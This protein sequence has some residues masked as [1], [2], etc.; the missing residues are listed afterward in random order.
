MLEEF[1]KY[2]RETQLFP[3]SETVLLAVSG[4]IDSIVMA[5]L[6]ARANFSFAI[7]HCNFRLRGEAS[8]GDEA[9]VKGLAAHYEVP[10]F[11]KKFDTEACAKDKQV[12]IQM[13]ARELRYQWFKDITRE[14]D[15]HHIALAHHQNDVLETMLFNLSKGTGLSGLHGILPRR[16]KLIRPLLFANKVMIENF[17]SQN[18]LEWREDSSNADTK[19]TRN[20]LRHKVLPV[21]E[22]INPN[23]YQTLQLTAERI[24]GAETLMLYLVEQ[25][26]RESTTHKGQDFFIHLPKLSGLPGLAVIIHEL[27][28][29]YGFQYMQSREIVLALNQ[30]EKQKVGRIFESPTHRLNIDR[31]DL[32]VSPRKEEETNLEIEINGDVHRLL[33]DEM[34]LSMKVLDAQ[35]Y[36]I[37]PLKN[38]AALDHEK[39]R[40]PL[41]MRKWRE[42]DWFFPLGMNA[43]KKL[44]D[45]MI[46]TKIPLNLKD[47]IFVLTSGEDIIWVMG[48]RIDHRFRVTE[49]TRQVFEITR[50]IRE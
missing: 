42:G 37:M 32:I 45:F 5:E 24:R 21:M 15:I 26:R 30:K 10:F 44:S 27:I 38:I 19:Y 8:D 49:E 12:S 34:E 29:D 35:Q 43:K 6:F 31:H 1:I 28:K 33:T 41:K 7:A 13:A 25:L 23:L 18:Q 11:A 22:Q 17:A 46:D 50:E 47:K 36:C 16:G 4:G 2:H 48:H 39:L 9:F 3:A 14:N 20:L 40:F